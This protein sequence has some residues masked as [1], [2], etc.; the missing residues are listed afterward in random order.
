MGSGVGVEVVTRVGLVPR[1][2]KLVVGQ[3]LQNCLGQDAV[4]RYQP[5]EAG[6]TPTVAVVAH[7]EVVAHG[8]AEGLG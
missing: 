2:P 4:T 5:E 3:N 7:D 6:V 8:Y 1:P